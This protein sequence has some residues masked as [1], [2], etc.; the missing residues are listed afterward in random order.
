MLLPLQRFFSPIAGI[1]ILFILSP[2]I[3]LAQGA[4]GSPEGNSGAAGPGETS[5]PAGWGGNGNSASD[6]SGGGIGS[7]AAAA[8]DAAASAAAADGI[9]GAAGNSGVSASGNADGSVDIDFDGDGNPDATIDGTDPAAVA[10]ATAAA[11]SISAG[12]RNGEVTPE[13]VG[14]SVKDTFE[15]YMNP[16]IDMCSGC[17]QGKD[18][19]IRGT[20]EAVQAAEARNTI[21]KAGLSK[22]TNAGAALSEH[23]KAVQN[24]Q[25]LA[26]PYGY[27]EDQVEI[28]QGT[29]ANLLSQKTITNWAPTTPTQTTPTAAIPQPN[30]PSSATALSPTTLGPPT[31]F[32]KDFVSNITSISYD[33]DGKITAKTYDGNTISLSDSQAEATFGSVPTS[34]N[35]TSVDTV[36]QRAQERGSL[37]ADKAALERQKE[38]V[39]SMDMSLADQAKTQAIDLDIEAIDK[40]ITALTNP[41]TQNLASAWAAEN[42]AAL[43]N[44]RA[45][46]V[47]DALVA[48]DTTKANLAMGDLNA[49]SSYSTTP[50]QDLANYT[51]YDNTISGYYDPV[52][53]YAYSAGFTDPEDF[54]N[55]DDAP[56]GYYDP[57][58]GGIVSI[59]DNPV[60][61]LYTSLIDARNNLQTITSGRYDVDTF[62]EF[63]PVDYTAHNEN[64]QRLAEINA[65]LAT[66]PTDDLDENQA[67]SQFASLP[68]DYSVWGQ[69]KQ[70]FVAS[71]YSSGMVS[72]DTANGIATVVEVGGFTGLGAV[73]VGSLP[74]AVVGLGLGIGLIGDQGYAVAK[75]NT[76]AKN[77]EALGM[78]TEAAQAREAAK[79]HLEAAVLGGA[80]ALGLGIGAK[81]FGSLGRGTTASKSTVSPEVA[82]INTSPQSATKGVSLANA[83]KST[84][85]TA[86]TT[87]NTGKVSFSTKPAVNESIV[88]EVNPAANKALVA[89][90]IAEIGQL[91]AKNVATEN[92]NAV[93]TVNAAKGVNTSAETISSRSTISRTTSKTNLAEA[94]GVANELAASID[95]LSKSLEEAA[96]AK[97]E[98]AFAEAQTK[99]SGA[100]N[101]VSTASNKARAIADS[102]SDPVISE[103]AATAAKQA[104]TATIQAQSRLRSLSYERN[105][106]AYSN[107]QPRVSPENQLTNLTSSQKSALRDLAYAI[108]GR[109]SPR[110]AISETFNS[111]LGRSPESTSVPSRAVKTVTAF[112]EILA[113]LEGPIAVYRAA[114]DFASNPAIAK[115][116]QTVRN[117][118][119]SQFPVEIAARPTTQTPVINLNSIPKASN[120]KAV[121][122]LALGTPTDNANIQALKENGYQV[123][124]VATSPEAANLAKTAGA[125][126]VEVSDLD[127]LNTQDIQKIADSARALGATPDNVPTPAGDN[128]FTESV[129]TPLANS[130]APTPSDSTNTVPQNVVNPSTQKTLFIFAATNN[131]NG[132][133]RLVDGKAY[134]QAP[135]QTIM[136]DVTKD[137]TEIINDAR[138]KGFTRIVVIPAAHVTGLYTTTRQAALAAGAEVI[139]VNYG[140]SEDPRA[141]IHLTYEGDINTT[142]KNFAA[143]LPGEKFVI[144]DSNARRTIDTLSNTF[145]AQS[146]GVVDATIGEIK[147]QLA[148]IPDQSTPN[149]QTRAP[150]NNSIIASN[151]VSGQTDN[152]TNNI[153]PDW[154][155]SLWDSIRGVST[156]LIGFPVAPATAQPIY[157]SPIVEFRSEAELI[158]TA[159][160]V[161]AEA[162]ILGSEN[163]YQQAAEVIKHR[164]LAPAKSFPNTATEVIQQGNG[165]QFEVYLLKDGKR[166]IDQV[167]VNTAEFAKVR[168]IVRQVFASERPTIAVTKDGYGHLYFGN[169]NTINNSR[170][171]AARLLFNNLE[172]PLTVRS[173]VAN[174]KRYMHV[175]GVAPGEKTSGV[176]VKLNEAAPLAQI[177]T[178]QT[179]STQPSFWSNLRNIWG[180][181]IENINIKISFTNP[182]KSQT[183]SNPSE[184]KS[185]LTFSEAGNVINN[186]DVIYPHTGGPIWGNS[187]LDGYRKRIDSKGRTYDSHH[188]GLDSYSPILKSYRDVYTPGDGEI[189]TIN[190]NSNGYGKYI[191]I[192][193]TSGLGKGLVFFVAHVEPNPNLKRGDI[194][195]AGDIVAKITGHGTSF[196][197]KAQEFS[198]GRTIT[199]EG[200]NKAVDFYSLSNGELG[201]NLNEP[202][203]SVT[204]PH[205]HIEFRPAAGVKGSIKEQNILDIKKGDI[206]IGGLQNGQNPNAIQEPNLATN[207]TSPTPTSQ[208]TETTAR[209]QAAREQAGSSIKE[210]RDILSKDH[211]PTLATRIDKAGQNI[212]DRFTSSDI[213]TLNGDAP[214]VILIAPWLNTSLE[215]LN[216][217]AAQIKQKGAQV[218]ILED[219][220]FGNSSRNNKTVEAVKSAV[221]KGATLELIF[222]H[223]RGGM[224]AINIANLLAEI[225]INVNTLIAGDPHWDLISPPK[226]KSNV[227]NFILYQ[228]NLAWSARYGEDAFIDPG[229]TETS[230]II[231][232]TGGLHGGVVK[233]SNV[234]QSVL[235]SIPDTNT[236]TATPSNTATDTYSALIKG[237]QDTVI[238]TDGNVTTYTSQVGKTNSIEFYMSDENGSYPIIIEGEFSLSYNNTNGTFTISP[239][240]ENGNLSLKLG[241]STVNAGSAEF[242]TVS[243]NMQIT[244]TL[245]ENDSLGTLDVKPLSDEGITVTA[246]N[247]PLLGQVT[248]TSTSPVT[249]DA[250]KSI[251]SD[252]GSVAER[253]LGWY[254]ER[255]PEFV[256]DI[257]KALAQLDTNVRNNNNVLPSLDTLATKINTDTRPTE[258]KETLEADVVKMSDAIEF[259]VQTLEN[260]LGRENTTEEQIAE[261]NKELNQLK[262]AAAYTDDAKKLIANDNLYEANILLEEAFSVFNNVTTNTAPDSTSA[263]SIP[264]ILPNTPNSITLT[265]TSRMLG[266]IA[267]GVANGLGPSPIPVNLSVSALPS[268]PE[269]GIGKALVASMAAII[270]ALILKI[271]FGNDDSKGEETT[272]TSQPNS[273]NPNEGDSSRPV[274]KILTDLLGGNNDTTP[275]LS[276]TTATSTPNGTET[277]L[278][279]IK[280]DRTNQSLDFSIEDIYNS[281]GES[282]MAELL[283]TDEDSDII[284]E[285]NDSLGTPPLI[286]S[287]DY[288]AVIYSDGTFAPVTV[289]GIT[290]PSDEDPEYL[291]VIEYY[292]NGQLVE[293]PD[294]NQILPGNLLTNILG[295]LKDNSSFEITDVEQIIRTL[296]D[297]NNEIPADEYYVYQI[298]LSNSKNR[299][300]AVPQYTSF[301][302]LNNRF[303]K[304]GFSGDV[305][306]LI[307]MAVETTDI[308]KNPSK[309]S[310]MDR[311]IQSGV[312]LMKTILPTEDKNVTSTNLGNLTPTE[313]GVIE[314]NDIL[315]ATVFFG[316][317]ADCPAVAGL[318]A[319]YLYEVVISQNAMPAASSD[320]ALRAVRCGVGDRVDYVNQVANHLESLEGFGKIDKAQLSELIRF[321]NLSDLS[322]VVS[323]TEEATTPTTEISTT[324]TKTSEP[325]PE[326]KP[327]TTNTIELQVK[328]TDYSGN[329]LVDWTYADLEINS[330]VNLHFKW[331][332]RDYSQCLPSFNEGGSYALTRGSAQNMTTGNTESEGYNLPETSGTY[333]IECGGQRNGEFGVDSREIEITL[334]N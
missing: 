36:N 27:N 49:L 99:V 179:T 17:V 196:G 284:N 107:E 43:A 176:A 233:Q 258:T 249:L 216:T 302:F 142:I 278:V 147:Q 97:T 266:T 157:Y 161:H 61:D 96:G 272:D 175:S 212:T 12:T 194:V 301:A 104:N 155:R 228:P 63:E 255:A 44:E 207:T 133:V 3:A 260:L 189:V 229:N 314:M 165:R 77:F 89:E 174:P 125:S 26:K 281:N 41:T 24:A 80:L 319:P 202:R 100:I 208:S 332:A 37:E 280:V 54:N 225:G 226:I 45:Q 245:R 35:P 65:Q 271:L 283:D 277:V 50:E 88:F 58:T 94:K 184:Q 48:G 171:R 279:K 90:G 115:I 40:Q 76:A 320:M 52:T 132:T 312:S 124:G 239:R 223:S 71:M 318:Y 237:L 118:D 191:E 227:K 267:G 130:F 151:R 10:E 204:P 288:S 74:A 315:K 222:G 21:S 236:K 220:F 168:E 69:T 11:S 9:N 218:I 163:G 38:N 186:P 265:G 246:N 123:V 113:V 181:T 18:T 242:N 257:S 138:K 108:E 62:N 303:S 136:D 126:P 135:T 261:I 103:T 169:L 254:S 146:S 209:I 289:N 166:S 259:R 156:E 180:S 158:Y 224:E 67:K 145:N 22:A 330:N 149:L 128:A 53:G 221:A 217:L 85:P 141:A 203:W 134:V 263:D 66:F 273:S 274:Q 14:I 248:R 235:D 198:G 98:A 19:G 296:V 325:L 95:K 200:F 219:N 290:Y 148:R 243:G 170:S 316:I 8:P 215:E 20:P 327:N 70:G 291:Y 293:V 287:E 31:S 182:I 256:A 56:L 82:N 83:Q 46:A 79:S 250:D 310:L 16:N 192:K 262:T 326:I 188:D 185:Q 214:I 199:D 298:T 299:V 60:K 39:I 13:S 122:V 294:N 177:T 121:A 269:A 105:P 152:S 144:G 64:V 268:V 240:E 111:I 334:T 32:S 55:P 51:N 211:S 321:A 292:E 131:A 30:I 241:Q 29:L 210:I 4:E 308:V 307:N 213:P 117:T 57:V 137:L 153:L 91:A 285:E 110:Q 106:S 162:R 276:E 232:K 102:A 143:S 187:P 313:D 159:K 25:D 247:V 230:Q 193:L 329:T 154:A 323:Q 1:L 311:L 231:R 253:S 234:R 328:A 282:Y 317:E 270:A 275:V 164:V 116:I 33:D 309:A 300:V 305:I 295:L 244:G 127:N 78:T 206:T 173:E 178:P 331:D 5:A 101:E 81:G 129:R 252:L 114:P 201:W 333:R 86:N 238:K 251:K 195:K 167:N 205:A 197:N 286:L 139:D 306:Q 47:A 87:G 6:Y 119:Q 304:I 172:D 7:D 2:Y 183:T 93:N 297:P 75:A 190:H 59:P 160:A 15:S 23:V 324:T 72:F 68:T 322:S 28:A 92:S 34:P 112:A 150:E 109:T 140:N 73:A 120:P 264:G 42:K 84:S